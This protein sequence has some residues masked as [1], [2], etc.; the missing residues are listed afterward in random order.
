MKKIMRVFF[1]VLFLSVVTTGGFV[2]AADGA[3]PDRYLYIFAHQDDETLIIGHITSMVKAGNDVYVIW[4]TDGAGTADAVQR[5]KEARAAVGSVGVKQERMYF[6]KFPDRHSYRNVREI[7]THSLEIARK[8]K[9][10][11]I[12]ADAY[13]GG[14]MDHDVTN[15]IAA[16]LRKDVPSVREVYEFPL[17]NNAAG[18]QRTNVFIPFEGI[19]T[20]YT[21]VDDE[22]LKIKVNIIDFYPSQANIAATLKASIDKKKLKKYGEPYRVLPPHDYHVPPHAGTLLYEAN[23]RNGISFEDWKSVVVPFVDEIV[24]KQN[25]A[26]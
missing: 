23:L 4:T 26:K 20:L 18:A 24:A 12:F 2:V 10:T 21:P 7:Y 11:Y 3:A 1:A 8:V 5:E 25:R 13:E 19:D 6:L 15:V 14:S 17:Y 22:I 16:L 9:P